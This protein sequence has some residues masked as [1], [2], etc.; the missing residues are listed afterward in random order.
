MANYC[1]AGIKSLRGTLSH[2]ASFIL[3]SLVLTWVERGGVWGTILTGLK[4]GELGDDPYLGGRKGE[5]S[6]PGWKK[7]NDHYLGGRRGTIITWV[8]ERE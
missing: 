3:M 2:L 4:E 6:L 5:R 1:R 8:E 7:G